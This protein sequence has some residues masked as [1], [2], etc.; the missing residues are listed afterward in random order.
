MTTSPN[1]LL[2]AAIDGWRRQMVEHGDALVQTA[3]DLATELRRE[4]DELPGMRVLEGELVREAASH[5]LDRL[6]ILD[7]RLRASD[8]RLSGRRLAAPARTH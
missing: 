3:L 8:Q 2:Y 7:R 1:V 4:I 5:D 6:Q